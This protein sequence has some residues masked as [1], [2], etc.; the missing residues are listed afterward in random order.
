MKTDEISAALARASSAVLPGSPSRQDQDADGTAVA[1][2]LA[3]RIRNALL[4]TADVKAIE[5]PPALVDQLLYLDSLAMLYG[6]SGLGK[7]FLAIDWTLH[8]AH[9]SWWQGRAVKGVRAL[10]VIAEGASGAGIRTTAWETHHG[11]FTEAHPVDWLPWAVN[12][13]DPAWAGAL[14]E[15]VAEGGYQLVVLDTFARC[16]VG[17]EENSARDVGAIVANLDHIRRATGACVLLVHHSGKDSSAGARGS[18]ALRAA[19]TTELELTGEPSRLVL[20]TRKQKDAPEANP[21]TLSL[22]AVGESV[23]IDRAGSDDPENLPASVAATLVAL[24]QIDVPGGVPAS[25]WLKSVDVPERTFYRHRKGLLD[26]GL[27]INVG[28]EKQPRYTAVVG[29]SDAA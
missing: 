3:R 15:V 4:G 17:A 7:T 23:V 9:A 27:V 2:P 24:E 16:V 20:H 8:V 14:A 6:G 21:I 1:N 29:E 25:A 18:S 22:R 12:V 19:M 26:Q 13:S 11:A 10:Y 5:P 28:T